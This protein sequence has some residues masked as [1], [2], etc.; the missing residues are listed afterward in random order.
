MIYQNNVQI[1]VA[2]RSRPPGDG[3]FSWVAASWSLKIDEVADNISLDGAMLLEFT[4]LGLKVMA[5]LGIPLMLIMGPLDVYLGGDESHGDVMSVASMQN[6]VPGS[7]LFWAYMVIVWLVAIVV[8]H[9]VW[10]AK[11]SFM[12]R[13]FKWMKEMH[14]PRATSI[15]VEDIPENYR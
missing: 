6:L 1:D 7:K 9:F 12:K 4:H 5:A 15:M 10:N 14:K 2:P 13:R 3:Y 11:R 8:V